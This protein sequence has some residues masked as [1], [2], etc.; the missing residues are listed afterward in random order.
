[1]VVLS[2]GFQLTEPD[3]GADVV[4]AADVDH[5]HGAAMGGSR[6]NCV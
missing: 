5:V 4:D 3:S 1:M 6:H 2:I